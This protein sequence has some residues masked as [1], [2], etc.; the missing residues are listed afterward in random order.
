MQADNADKARRHERA[1][2]RERVVCGSISL[3][4][5]NAKV[6]P[7][8]K[9]LNDCGLTTAGGLIFKRAGY[10]SIS[11]RFANGFAPDAL[12]PLHF[13]LSERL[14]FKSGQPRR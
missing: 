6:I 3:T 13:V 4:V 8:G 1:E 12:R 9:R 11:H 7:S 10:R 14:V 2:M 5:L